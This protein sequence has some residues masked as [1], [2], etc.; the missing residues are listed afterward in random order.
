MLLY[1][2]RCVIAA[3]AWASG[4]E[5][6]ALAVS[7]AGRCANEPTVKD[8]HLFLKR[9]A[10]FSSIAWLRPVRAGQD[11]GVALHP[12]LILLMKLL[13]FLPRHFMALDDFPVASIIEL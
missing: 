13:R 11:R 4:L 6:A 2:F 9:L 8:F 5:K 7:L 10:S 12:D 1:V 3:N